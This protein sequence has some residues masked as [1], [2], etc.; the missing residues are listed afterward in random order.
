MSLRKK[1]QLFPEIDKAEFIK[2]YQRNTLNKF[3]FN[4]INNSKI[5]NNSLISPIKTDINYYLESIKKSKKKN[6]GYNTDNTDYSS[7]L[8]DCM[9][10]IN[11]NSEIKPIFTNIKFNESL[12]KIHKAETRNAYS[13]TNNNFINDRI[14]IYQLKSNCN[15]K[16]NN[17]T[18]SCWFTKFDNLKSINKFDMGKIIKFSN[19]F[20]N[21]KTP[22]IKKRKNILIKSK[23]NKNRFNS[24]NCFIDKYIDFNEDKLLNRYQPNYE[25]FFS[26]LDYKEIVKKGKNLLKTKE[27]II[28]VFKKTKLILAMCDYL[29]GSFGKLRNEKRYKMK[30]ISEANEEIMK[31][32]KYKK[33]IEID[34]KN[35]IIPKR[36]LFKLDRKIK[37]QNDYFKKAPK[38]YKNGYFSKTFY[39]PTSLS[40][41]NIES[42]KEKGN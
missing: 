37:I 13:N 6:F 27:K 38:I 25:K 10:K 9:S 35:N 16:R 2:N 5:K 1:G 15:N 11:G 42:N 39:F 40:Y 12:S 3:G 20:I 34:I 14:N 30:T 31:N 7:Q 26:N 23:E 33:T 18:S 36:D 17:K 24:L 22:K 32:Q 28:L 19:K 29:N 4:I 41:N 8:N 21:S